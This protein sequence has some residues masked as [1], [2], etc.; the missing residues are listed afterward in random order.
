[1][2]NIDQYRDKYGKTIGISFHR[3]KL[4]TANM[5]YA[6]ERPFHAKTSKKPIII[7]H[8]SMQE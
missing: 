7:N 5:Y 6:E 2:T 1:M 8:K 4:V 3:E